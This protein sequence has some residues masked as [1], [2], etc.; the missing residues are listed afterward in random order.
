M[1]TT[2]LALCLKP[3]TEILVIASK[4]A[5]LLD[6]P[7][8]CLQSQRLTGSVDNLQ[9][10]LPRCVSAFCD[11][12]KGPVS[13][14]ACGLFGFFFFKAHTF[15]KKKKIFSKPERG[16]HDFLHGCASRGRRAFDLLAGNEKSHICISASK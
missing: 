14:A 2:Y 16:K 11:I 15:W 5:P 10:R 1:Q 3:P 12:T 9:R 13:N 7:H 6:H 8:L 4:T